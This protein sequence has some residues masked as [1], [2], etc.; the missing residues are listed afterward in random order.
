MGGSG[1]GLAAVS[2]EHFASW[3]RLFRVRQDIRRYQ[4]RT[5]QRLIRHAADQVPYYRQAFASAQLGPA[6]LGSLDDLGRFPISSKNDFQQAPLAS[7]FA[8]GF[9]VENCRLHETSGSTGERMLIAR[10]PAE[11]LRLFGRRLRS[12][13]LNGLR[14]WHRRLIIGANPRQLAAHKLGVFR[15][16]GIDLSHSPKEMSAE[17]ERRRPHILKGPPSA[18]ELLLEED[19]QR[20]SAL[21]LQLILTGAEQLPGGLRDRLEECCACPVLDSYGAVECN[22]IAWE[23][24]RCGMFHTCDDSVIVEVLHGDRPA[25]PGEEG[26]VVVTALHSYAMPF[27][28]YRIG[29]QVSLPVAAP[30]CSIPF[31]VIHKVQGR[32][33]DYLRFPGNIAV[34]PYQIMDQLDSL[35]EVRRYQVVQD[36][37]YS[38][39]VK[40]EALESPDSALGHRVCDSLKQVLPGNAVIEACRVDRID[41]TVAAKR[42]FVQSRITSALA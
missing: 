6:D 5:L 3:A 2:L 13:I 24:R 7:R 32:S 20:L 9:N 11:E 27:I 4:L 18:L 40:F 21:S 15:T 8:D 42:R 37:S 17:A 31:G 34:S 38:V 29:D 26:E 39:Q 10:T 25:L 41:A 14:P 35:P 19:P 36:E 22:L 23:C 28:R 33:I 30:S 1:N 16:S 12:Q